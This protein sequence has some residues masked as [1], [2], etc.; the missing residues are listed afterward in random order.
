MYTE[1][2]VI[3]EHDVL[4]TDR[5]NVSRFLAS[6]CRYSLISSWQ[7][8]SWSCHQEAVEVVPFLRGE[9]KI[10]LANNITYC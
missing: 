3:A 2:V 6:T 4:I 7:Y 9:D 5:F 1:A 10:A 8:K